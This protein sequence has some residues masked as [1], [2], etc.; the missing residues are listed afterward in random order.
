MQNE[1]FAQI[2]LFTM[3]Q[4]R[5]NCELTSKEQSVS[6]FIAASDWTSTHQKR[7]FSLLFPMS[8]FPFPLMTFM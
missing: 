6:V 7:R 5:M 3:Y 1:S 8:F 2:V 4:L